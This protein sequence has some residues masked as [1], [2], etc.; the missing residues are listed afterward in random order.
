M[1]LVLDASLALAWCFEGEATAETNAIRDGLNGT[2]AVAPAIFALEVANTLVVAE[3]RKRI[4]R[5]DIARFISLLETLDLRLD[6]SDSERAFGDILDLARQLRLTTYDAAYLDLAMRQ[7]VPLATR[8]QALR[9][10]A[11]SCGVE[12]LPV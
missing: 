10:A 7:R 3:R 4:T 2:Y 1:T 5:R 9:T 11:Q 6:A 12:A 8:D